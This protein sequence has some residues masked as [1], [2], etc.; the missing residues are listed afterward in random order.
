[1]RAR[2]LRNGAQQVLETL[3]ADLGQHAL[4]FS[5]READIAHALSCSMSCA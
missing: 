1:L 4:L 2:V 5:A 3:D